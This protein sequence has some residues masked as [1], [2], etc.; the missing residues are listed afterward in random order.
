MITFEEK[1]EAIRRELGYRRRVYARRVEL[2]QMTQKLADRQIE[3]F[4]AIEKDYEA[5]AKTGRLL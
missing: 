5:A 1:L 4:E 3:L 2:N